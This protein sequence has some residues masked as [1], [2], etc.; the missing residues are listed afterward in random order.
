MGH[1]VD[2][3]VANSRRSSDVETEAARQAH[4]IKWSYIIGIPDPCGP[5][6]G[7]QRIVAIYTKYVQCGVNY[8]NIQVLHSATV[9]GYAEAVNNLF[10]L[11]RFAP[12]ANLTNPNNMTSILVTNMLR[13]EEIT[14]QRSPLNNEIF[15]QLRNTA[16][17]SNCD[18]SVHNLLFD[19]LALGCYIGPRLSEYAQTT[20]DKVDYHTYPS[21]HQVI[22]A[23]ITNDYI[24]YNKRR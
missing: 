2:R 20:Q 24:F 23:F 4:Y 15:A 16:K 13:K 17:A 11:C 14:Q 22:K 1:R 10:R 8:N 5:Y 6:L 21:G 9:R 7:Y 19:I 12:P 3:E 18:D